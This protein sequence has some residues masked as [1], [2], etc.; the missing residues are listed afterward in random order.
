V[1][2]AIE[3]VVFVVAAVTVLVNILSAIRSVVLPRASRQLVS[4]LTVAVTRAGLGVRARR[5]ASYGERDRIMA[6]LA[7]L[8]LV[9]MLVTWLLVIFVAYAVM[10]F[11]ME[12]FSVQDAVKL[13]GSSLVTLGT[14]SDPRFWPSMLSYSEAALG[15]L[16]VAL[17]ITYFPS[18]YAAFTRREQ[19]VT[20]LQTRAGSPPEPTKMLIRYHV[21]EGR[22]Q[23]LTELWHTWETWFVDLEES[24][25]TFRVLAY[26]R[27]PQPDRSWITAAG[28]LLDGAA[29]WVACVDHPKDADAQL[30]LRSGYLALRRVADGFGIRYDPNPDPGDPISITRGEWDGAMAELD[31][32]G[33][34]L[35]ADRDQAW[36]DWAGWRVN[37]DTV[38]LELA[39]TVEA[40]MVPWV[41]DRSP[42]WPAGRHGGR[43]A[44]GWRRG[45]RR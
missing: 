37:Y 14:A 44:T 36:R 11:C 10:F 12:G 1:R 42:I 3:T 15:L 5:S 13:S 25:S 9:G 30:T 38:L 4:R 39:R 32:A 28:A 21:I 29:F 18:I 19:G 26:F 17:F 8:A 41:S 40:P 24:H 45:P 6:M 7:P 22:L 2:Q 27:S 34:P 31:E 35:V 33:V 20:L 43:T 23:E 16:L